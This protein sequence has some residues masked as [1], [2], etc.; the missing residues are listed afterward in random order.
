MIIVNGNEEPSSI[1]VGS[2]DVQAVYSGSQLV[3]PKH[4]YNPRNLE[5]VSKIDVAAPAS[6]RYGTCNTLC[7]DNPN[8]WL[9]FDRGYFDDSYEANLWYYSDDQGSTWKVNDNKPNGW[10][11]DKP[12]RPAVYG[13]SWNGSVWLAWGYACLVMWSSD[14]L[15]WEIID[16]QGLWDFF[17]KT[18]TQVQF[19]VAA[20]REDGTWWVYGKVL[21]PMP[22]D[23]DHPIA[24]RIIPKT[25]NRPYTWENMPSGAPINPNDWN[26]PSRASYVATGPV[27]TPQ[28]D[29]VCVNWFGTSDDT[30][31]KFTHRS[32]TVDMELVRRSDEGNQEQIMYH[33]VDGWS[34]FI[35]RVSGGLEFSESNENFTKHDL[36]TSSGK[37]PWGLHHI[38][39]NKETGQVF[40]MGY[41]EEGI[42]LE[43]KNLFHLYMWHPQT[44][45]EKTGW[46][47]TARDLQQH[48]NRDSRPYCIYSQG[49]RFV[50]QTWHPAYKDV[51]TYVYK[52]KQS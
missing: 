9:L 51:A 27:G 35:A 43:E 26:D 28:N 34:G 11:T 50:I 1:K 16:Q 6:G 10:Y 23:Q 40:L 14:G 31:N 48:P 49:D 13:V 52:W 2:K 45:I 20:P 8:R 24:I 37:N 42:I 44:G 18:T 36:P 5:L 30:R 12:P 41:S 3:W 15:N 7:I 38:A 47:Y 32:H 22:E 19:S 25:S 29:Y 17:H 4:P 33:S 21:P 46:C 39:A